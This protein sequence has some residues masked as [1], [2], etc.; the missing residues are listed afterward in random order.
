MKWS[1]L[2]S[3]QIFLA[4]LEQKEKNRGHE[5]LQELLSAMTPITSVPTRGE[6]STRYPGRLSDHADTESLNSLGG[7]PDIDRLDPSVGIPLRLDQD[8]AS[9]LARK[10]HSSI[11][12]GG[13]WIW[14][15]TGGSCLG[16]VFNIH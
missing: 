12:W 9:A 13:V 15:E 2:D 4:D 6:T 7:C 14:L 11:V 5:T 1:N 8:K 16:P 3:E 10:H